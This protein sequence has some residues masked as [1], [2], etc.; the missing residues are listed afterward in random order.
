MEEGIARLADEDESDLD[1]S[2]LV[3]A[4]HTLEAISH[5]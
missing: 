3:T 4:R 1:E 5:R 2:L